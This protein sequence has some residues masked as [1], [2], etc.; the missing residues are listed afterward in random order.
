MAAIEVIPAGTQLYEVVIRDADYESRHDVTVPDELVRRMD[1]E[2]V[3]MQDIVLTAVE[4]LLEREGH[5]SLQSEIDLGAAADRHEGLVDQIPD[6]ARER[7]TSTNPPTGMHV[8]DREELAGDDRLLADVEEDQQAG[9]ASTQ[10]R[11]Y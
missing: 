2:R 4:F 6:R 8:D 1:T 10:E 11:R 9:R 7:A 5:D 3:A